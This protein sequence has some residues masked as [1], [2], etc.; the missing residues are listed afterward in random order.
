MPAP[1]L[2]V[3]AAATPFTDFSGLH[4]WLDFSENVNLD[5]SD[6]PVVRVYVRVANTLRQLAVLSYHLETPRR[7]DVRLG[8]A[9][10]TS[11]YV[12]LTMDDP[13]SL[14]S[15]AD[16]TLANA[17]EDVVVLNQSTV[18]YPVLTTDYRY[19]TPDD[20]VLY[21]GQKVVIEWSNLNPRQ[22]SVDAA[23]LRLAVLDAQDEL[24]RRLTNSVYAVPL[25]NLSNT[26]ALFLRD[27]V[28]KLAMVWL[29]DHRP[30]IATDDKG[31]PKN[32]GQVIRK[33]VDRKIVNVIA[34]QYVLAS[35]TRRQNTPI[36]SGHVHR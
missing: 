25:V 35:A 36:I 16:D 19:A 11:E 28:V 27:L 30:G 3:V 33:D 12:T 15:A 14:R 7:V 5:P 17:F 24:E 26:D 34:Q 4:V 1:I 13:G 10:F 18:P 32:L 9:A 21:F 31:K 29:Y 6:P 2:S 23:R 20:V 8:T 22:E